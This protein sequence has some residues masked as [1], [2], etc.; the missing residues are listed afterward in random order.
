MHYQYIR[1]SSRATCNGLTLSVQREHPAQSLRATSMGHHAS[2]SPSNKTRNHG[3]IFENF[4]LKHQKT[5]IIINS[6]TCMYI[7]V[8]PFPPFFTY[9]QMQ[10]ICMWLSMY[11][12]YACMCVFMYICYFI[13]LIVTNRN[14]LKITFFSSG[15]FF[16]FFLFSLK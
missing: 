15:A 9:M 10:N 14:K 1:G 11:C 4:S 16:F 5:T 8:F 12:M 3:A 13:M 6:I 2:S 7:Y